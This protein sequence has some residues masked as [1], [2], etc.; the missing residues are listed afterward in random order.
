[1][2]CFPFLNPQEERKISAAQPKTTDSEIPQTL[3]E[4]KY[5]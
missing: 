1:M 3:E 4:E 2:V 5:E